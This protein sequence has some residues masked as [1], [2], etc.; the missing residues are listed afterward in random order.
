MHFAL[1]TQGIAIKQMMVMAIMMGGDD[2]WHKCDY[3]I[4]M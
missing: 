2:R 4:Q 3:Y 1:P